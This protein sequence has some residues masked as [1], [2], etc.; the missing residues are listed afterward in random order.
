MQAV[1]ET[2]AFHRAAR[3]LGLTEEDRIRIVTILAEN[4]TAGDLIPGTGGAQKLRYAPAGRGKSGAYRV[5]TY[6]GGEDVPVFLLDIYGK[7]EKINLSQAE[8]N[9]LRKILGGIAEDWRQSV[10]RSVVEKRP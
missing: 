2:H 8:K 6:F 4:P 9:E 7:G 10:R 3:D 1:L 5:I